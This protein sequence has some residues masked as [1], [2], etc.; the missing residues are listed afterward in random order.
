M[1]RKPAVCIQRPT[2][3]AQTTTK[4]VSHNQV[5]KLPV[6]MKVDSG[7]GK[8]S[9]GRSAT[10]DSQ[11]GAIERGDGRTTTVRTPAAASSRA[12]QEIGGRRPT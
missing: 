9:H 8:G 2:A 6:Q 7:M 5:S 3:G 11:S 10:A 12:S 1:V 4:I